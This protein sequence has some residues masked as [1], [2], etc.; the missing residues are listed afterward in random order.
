MTNLFDSHAHLDDEAFDDDRD[1]IIENCSA[2]LKGVINPG[3]D[4]DSS[5][6][7]VKLSEENAVIYSAVG[8]HPHEA[9][10]MQPKDEEVLAEL[11][12]NKKVVAIGEIGLDY[13]YDYSPRDV[14]KTVFIRHLD[15]ARQLSLPVIIHDRD[16]HGDILEIIKNEGQGIRGVFHCYSGSWE[17]AKVILKMG[18]YISFGGSLTFKNAVKTVEVAKNIPDDMMLLETDS[19]YLTP[20]PYRGKRNNPCMVEH[21]CTKMAELKD[22][23]FEQVA[24]ITT[25]N[26]MALF[27]RICI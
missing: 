7:A 23:E 3:S 5:K 8:F 12:K 19:P 4:M 15:L 1:E 27:N 18:W 17:M 26:V 14:Q 11:A 2:R 6:K 22:M 9:R 21:V 25:K 16:A 13:Y 24:D 20:V 10:L